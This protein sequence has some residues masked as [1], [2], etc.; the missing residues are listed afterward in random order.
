MYRIKSNHTENISCVIKCD[1]Q[2]DRLT[3]KLQELLELLFGTKNPM[4]EGFG[5]EDGLKVFHCCQLIIL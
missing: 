5:G 3:D 1:R 4:K 2:S